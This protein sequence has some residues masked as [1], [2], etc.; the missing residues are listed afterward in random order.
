VN[1]LLKKLATTTPEVSP[2]ALIVTVTTQIREAFPDDIDGALL[3]YM[4]GR[5][6]GRNGW[7]RLSTESFY[8]PGTDFMA[9]V[10]ALLLLE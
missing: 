10:E 6:A 8:S 7:I 4:A 9:R 1:K 2:G 3:A 5:K